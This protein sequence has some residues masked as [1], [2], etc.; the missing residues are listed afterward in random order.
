MRDKSEPLDILLKV[1]KDLDLKVDDELIKECYQL[2]K[3]YQYVK[4]RDT[5][6]KM[7]ALIE[8]AVIDIEG[9]AL[10]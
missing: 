8:Q 2:Q 4:E 9:D 7:K 5:A 3:E 1:K 10:L 6:R